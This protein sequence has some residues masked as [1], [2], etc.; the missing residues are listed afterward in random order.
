MELIKDLGYLYPTETSK[1]KS[2]YGLY[3]CSCGVEFKARIANVERNHTKSC[4]CYDTQRKTTHGLTKHRLFLTWKNMLR[5][6]TDSKATKY[7]NYGGRGITVCKEW[8]NVENF[9]NDMYPT[10]VEGL[11]LD[12]KDNN[13]NYNISNCRWATKTVQSRNTSLSKI[14]KSG[15]RG[16]SWYKPHSNWRARIQVGSKTIHLGYFEDKIKA[17]EAYD[18]YVLINRL[19]H[20]LNFE[21]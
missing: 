3:K 17:A 10:F 6:C 15:Y 21:L 4:G 12:R 2:K 5:R 9:I 11:T 8:L 1:Q 18:N 7:E 19:E 13:G 14:N 16:V 20:T